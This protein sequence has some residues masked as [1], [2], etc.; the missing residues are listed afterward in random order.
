M[1]DKNFEDT[2]IQSAV[3]KASREQRKKQ[4]KKRTTRQIREEMTNDTFEE[5]QPVVRV[6]KRSAEIRNKH[7]VPRD[8]TEYKTFQSESS[9]TD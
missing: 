2:E 6:A 3:F 1:S 4:K 9:F 8:R 7:K 5:H